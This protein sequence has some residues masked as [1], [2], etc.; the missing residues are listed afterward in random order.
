[1]NQIRLLGLL[2]T[3]SCVL[4]YR[5]QAQDARQKIAPE[6]MQAAAGQN[7][8]ECIVVF[9]SQ[10]DLQDL[11]LVRGKENKGREAYA[12]LQAAAASS[13]AEV[14][15]ILAA[16]TRPYRSFFIVNA[17]Y[18]TV[19]QDLLLQLAARPEVA[20]IQPNPW[21]MNIDLQAD[22]T[23]VLSA[24]APVEWGV[25]KINTPEVWAQGVNG[26]GVVIGGQDTGVEWT[27]PALKEKY[28]AWEG[29]E[30]TV[31][32]N[33]HWFD[34]ISELSP[35]HQD[36]NPSPANNRCGLMLA[37]PCDD[38]DHGTYTM[39]ISVGDDGAGNQTGVAPGARWIACRNMERGYGSPA[40]Y[41][42]G[43]EWFL[44]PTDLNGNNPRPE[45]APHVINN[46]WG[47]PEMEGCTLANWGIL[48]TAIEN[49]RSAGV[50]VIVSAGN[51]GPACNSI[52]DPPAIFA[53]AFSVG[54]TNRTDTLTG[55][56]SRGLVTVDGSNRLKPDVVAPGFQVRSARPDSRY[57]TSSGT[58][59]AGPFVVGVVALMIQANPD[60]AGEVEL[61]E[62]ILRETTVPAYDI[63]S[64]NGYTSADIPNPMT[65]YGRIDALA[66]VE[67]ARQVSPTQ[68][69]A[70]N[71][72]M[73]VYPN[74]TDGLVFFSLE[75]TLS[76]GTLEIFDLTG[77]RIEQRQVTSFPQEVDL[78]GYA[79]GM[80]YWRCRSGTR[81]AGGKLIRVG[82]K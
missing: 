28:R 24:R 2:L 76:T 56:S 50:V 41:L 46:S 18:T 54:A 78:S 72:R 1:M 71:L 15:R 27:H 62:Q 19:H 42:A 63:V 34:A 39:G 61:I 77:K 8:V 21:V 55:F 79:A 32:H 81:S 20:W 69:P 23:P 12:R 40:T 75:D 58:S 33:Y 73:R 64:C 52:F 65:G 47:C 9:R 11:P 82:G 16:A 68:E 3:F 57:M 6:L 7:A 5:V 36:P 17:L 31:D 74:P 51:D 43:F 14:R 70:G 80:Y 29:D 4:L 25:D 48:E 38:N 60:L 22:T 26:E 66:A 59:A 30:A 35:L 49:L 45:L 13:Q 44:A 67:R 53:N 10:T 37:A